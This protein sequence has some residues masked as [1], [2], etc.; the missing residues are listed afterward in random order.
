MLFRSVLL[1]SHT[2]GFENISITDLTDA[3]AGF[4]S[5]WRQLPFQADGLMTGYV[6]SPEQLQ[7]IADFAS[8]KGLVRFVDPIMADNGRLYAG[9]DQSFVAAM[10]AFC[11]EADII[12]P[13]LTEA[14]LL[15]DVPYLGDAYDQEAIE[16]LLT[17]LTPLNNKHIILTGVSFEDGSI[18]LAHWDREKASVSYHFAKAYPQN[19]FGTGDVLSAILAAGYFHGL[20]LDAVATLALDIIDKILSLTLELERDI[21]WGLCYEPYLGYLASRLM[22]LKEEKE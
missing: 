20:S 11:Q 15:A 1:S 10:R 5:Q 2:G 4:L 8:Q 3:T 6:K 9:Y 14:C 17:Q 18:G 21:K 13:N 12:T 22:V 19:F 16:H 7:Q